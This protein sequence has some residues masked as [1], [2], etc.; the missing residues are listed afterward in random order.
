[1]RKKKLRLPRC[2][3]AGSRSSSPPPRSQE[4]DEDLE[5]GPTIV[6]KGGV[7][8]DLRSYGRDHRR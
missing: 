4:D 6:N 7:E 2:S 3:A 8:V 1:M 5:P